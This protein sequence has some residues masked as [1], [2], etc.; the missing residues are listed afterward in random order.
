MY[1]LSKSYQSNALDQYK[2]MISLEIILH[3]HRYFFINFVFYLL[4]IDVLQQAILLEDILAL[5][6]N[7]CIKNHDYLFSY[8]KLAYKQVCL[9]CCFSELVYVPSTNIRKIQHSTQRHIL[10][11]RCIFQINI[12]CIV[13]HQYR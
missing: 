1:V 11:K 6:G 5:N 8:G 10:K 4:C 7:K 9:H 12:Y 13:V 2:I 3:H